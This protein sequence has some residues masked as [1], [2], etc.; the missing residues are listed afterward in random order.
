MGYHICPVYA[1]SRLVLLSDLQAGGVKGA[2]LC[3]GVFN[4]ILEPKF[5]AH[6]SGAEVLIPALN[7]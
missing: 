7:M 2:G 1:C 6:G 3:P 4:Q 5:S